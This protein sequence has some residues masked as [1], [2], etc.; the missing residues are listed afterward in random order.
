MYLEG[1]WD[2][3]P[4]ELYLRVRLA[5]A[6][7]M[8]KRAVARHFKISRDTADKALA[9]SVPP[10]YRRTAPIKRRKLDA[11]I[12]IIDAWSMSR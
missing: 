9:F 6:D 12:A 11:F 7:G 5:R 10:R 4:V 8:S 3:D 1:G 2:I